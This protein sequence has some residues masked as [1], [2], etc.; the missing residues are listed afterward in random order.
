MGEEGGNVAARSPGERSQLHSSLTLLERAQAGDRAALDLLVARY[1]PRLQ[2]WASG[3]LPR[4]A[5]DIADTQD[6]VQ[7]TLFQTFKRIEKFESRGEGALLAY[8]RQAILNRVREELRRAKRRPARN[9][10]E[11]QAADNARSPLEEAIGQEALERYERALATLRREDRELVVARVELGYTNQEIAELLDKPTP[12]AAR[13][14][15]ERAVIRLAK[16]M[17]KA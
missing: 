12:N 6:L 11:S 4:W 8:L 1:L 5:C 16:E 15:V 17:G 3:R 13:M 7:E 2:R 9:E 14:A 10:L